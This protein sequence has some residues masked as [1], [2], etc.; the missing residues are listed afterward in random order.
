MYKAYM[1]NEKLHLNVTNIT[2]LSKKNL[3]YNSLYFFI[4]IKY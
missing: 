1:I 2:N 3:M 4:D